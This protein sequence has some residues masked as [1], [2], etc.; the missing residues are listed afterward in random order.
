[1]D[2]ELNKL[3]EGA[4]ESLR[5]IEANENISEIIMFKIYDLIAHLKHER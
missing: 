5:W 3:I 2:E 4:E 1:M